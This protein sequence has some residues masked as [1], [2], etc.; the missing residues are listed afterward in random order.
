MKILLLEDDIIL[1]ELIEEYLSDLGYEVDISYEGYEALDK[2]TNNRYDLLLFD[3]GVPNLN[4][5]ELLEYLKSVDINI[6]VIYI[7]SLNQ[8]KDLEKAFSIGCDDYIKKPFELKELEVRINHLKKVYRLDNIEYKIKDGTVYIKS[9][10]KIISNKEESI[11]S[12]KE[13][14]V[15]EY[16]LKHPNQIISADELISNIW[17]DGDIPSNSTI[18]T[19]IKNLRKY[20]KDSLKTVKGYG[21]KIELG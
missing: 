20:L 8:A 11:L 6:P 17:K 12:K 9:E 1:N 7:T 4:G 19:Y 18:R 13:A 2:I 3:V 21:Y 10:K 14:M 15:L 16:F 5:F